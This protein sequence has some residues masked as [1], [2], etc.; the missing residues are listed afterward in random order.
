MALGNK[1]WFKP[2][3]KE[4]R[5]TRFLQEYNKLVKKYQWGIGLSLLAVGDPMDIMTK[6]EEESIPDEETK[7]D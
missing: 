6:E 4:E 3:T 5:K 1:N 2:L 7:E